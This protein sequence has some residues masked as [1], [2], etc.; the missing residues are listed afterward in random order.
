MPVRILFEHLEVGD[1][2]DVFLRDFAF[3]SREPNVAI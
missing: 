1:S 2:I 3:V